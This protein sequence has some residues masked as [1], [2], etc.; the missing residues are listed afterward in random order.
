MKVRPQRVSIKK[1][2]PQRVRYFSPRITLPRRV[3]V[4][5]TCLL[6]TS[7]YDGR[8][9]SLAPLSSLTG[10]NELYINTNV[11]NN[12][13]TPLG[14]LTELRSL[15]LYIGNW[16]NP[17]RDISPLANLTNLTSFSM[18][19]SADNLDTSPVAHVADLDIR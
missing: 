18:N 11:T 19:N 14:K 12:D 1:S 13:I 3:L 17:V 7:N 9:L 6:Y 8:S 2:C 16:D 4:L 5:S 10:L 15:T